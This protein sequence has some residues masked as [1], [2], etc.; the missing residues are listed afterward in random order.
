MKIRWILSD[1]SPDPPIIASTVI[2]SWWLGR[3]YLVT[4]TMSDG[5]Q[6]WAQLVQHYRL[7][8]KLDDTGRLKFSTQVFKS[9]KDGSIGR[10]TDPLSEAVHDSLSNAILGHKEAILDIDK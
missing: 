10:N 9:N 6:S 3:Y 1:P 5:T 8:V 2:A 7:G 4:T